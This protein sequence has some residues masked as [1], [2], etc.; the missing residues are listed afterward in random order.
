MN[1]KTLTLQEALEAGYTHFW[2][3]PKTHDADEFSVFPI[4]DE[5]IKWAQEQI[6]TPPIEGK[7]HEEWEDN[8]YDHVIMLCDKPNVAKIDAHDLSEIICDQIE[9]YSE[10]GPRIL[11]SMNENLKTESRFLEG[12]K[13]INEALS[14]YRYFSDSGIRLVVE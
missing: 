3:S 9:L 12:L 10:F 11:E 7:M 14:E 2:L 8:Y 6:S 5:Q 13:L 4:T 1:I